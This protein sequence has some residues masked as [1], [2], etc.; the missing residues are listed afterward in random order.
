MLGQN[1]NVVYSGARTLSSLETHTPHGPTSGS[2][3]KGFLTLYPQREETY[4][5]AVPGV[6]VRQ[7]EPSEEYTCC[8]Q[9]ASSSRFRVPTLPTRL[10]VPFDLN[11]SSRPTAQGGFQRGRMPET[12][13]RGN[14]RRRPVAV[15]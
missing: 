5:K 4:R 1:Q 2:A 11:A 13:V 8:I 15:S 7:H 9:V 12:G 6:S 3:P 14:T 10:L